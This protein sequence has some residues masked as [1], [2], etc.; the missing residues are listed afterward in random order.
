M[1]TDRG[2][3][4]LPNTLGTAQSNILSS[5]TLYPKL[6]KKPIAPDV[7]ALN[8]TVLIIHSFEGA[9]GLAEIQS[10]KE[11]TI[12]D[13]LSIIAKL[14]DAGEEAGTIEG[15]LLDLKDLAKRSAEFHEALVEWLK[16]EDIE[17]VKEAIEIIPKLNELGD[18][19]LVNLKDALTKIGFKNGLK[20]FDTYLTLRDKHGKD[21][22]EKFLNTVLERKL[23]VLNLKSFSFE[24]IHRVTLI[25]KGMWINLGR[26]L[27]A[28]IYGAKVYWSYDEDGKS[29]SRLVEFT[30]STEGAEM[31]CIPKKCVDEIR[32]KIGASG[33]ITITVTHIEIF[34]YVPEL[35]FPSKFSAG[36]KGISLD[37]FNGKLKVDKK[38]LQTVGRTLRTYTGDAVLEIT[39]NAKSMDGNLFVLV[40]YD[41]GKVSIQTSG[42]ARPIV[43]IEVDENGLL[44]IEF[45][46]TAG[47][48]ATGP[49]TLELRD[50][51]LS[52][53]LFKDVSNL[54]GCTSIGTELFAKLGY[55]TWQELRS[56]VGDDVSEERRLILLVYFYN[57]RIAYCGNEDFLVRL[58]ENAKSI[59]GVDIVAFKSLLEPQRWAIE[60]INNPTPDNIGKTGETMTL[61][62]LE[63][64]VLAKVSEESH[65]TAD[66]L[67]HKVHQGSSR[68]N[69]L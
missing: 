42:G 20:L 40:F 2:L 44:R 7:N 31:I 14:E 48:Y 45:A 62:W 5:K 63:E 47:S 29:V 23:D 66:K 50:G 13:V 53:E 43:N 9:K 69:G 22:A 65:I 61:T 24:E 41:S 4:F 32:S 21:V 17:A 18:E 39:T 1:A 51:K 10:V 64:S 33:E 15:F 27:D 57:G 58:P 28:G 19:E 30:F 3:T 8:V 46:G 26:K 12:L 34:T 56:R 68:G 67:L 59:V 55:D 11:E 54:K 6:A 36:G 37:L 16:S 49:N 60:V 25:E 52:L 38:E 35:M